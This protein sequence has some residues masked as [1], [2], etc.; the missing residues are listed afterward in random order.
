MPLFWGRG[1]ETPKHLSRK[2]DGACIFAPGSIP[3]VPAMP[4]P[5]CSRPHR[6]IPHPLPQSLNCQPDSSPPSLDGSTHVGGLES[7]FGALPPPRRS[8]ARC[9][10]STHPP[11]RSS[12][13]GNGRQPDRSCV[14]V[15]IPPGSWLVA[16]ETS[17]GAVDD[18]QW[19]SQRVRDGDILASN[20]QSGTDSC[21]R[22]D[23]QT[24][25]PAHL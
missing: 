19:T 4:S 7:L 16:P 15:T 2:R 18:G 21:S 13:T 6:S 3:L 10:A 25:K 24:A 12:V 11:P 5:R 1:G 20:F 17:R 22:Q 23:A 8:Q 9:K 14:S